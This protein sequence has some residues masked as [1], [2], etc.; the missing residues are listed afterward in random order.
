MNHL[1]KK[2]RNKKKTPNVPQKKLL[3]YTAAQNVMTQSIGARALWSLCE[4]LHLKKP[5]CGELFMD[6]KQLKFQRTTQTLVLLKPLRPQGKSLR[7]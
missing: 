7:A 4:L 1:R 3:Y 2:E 5:K 6:P